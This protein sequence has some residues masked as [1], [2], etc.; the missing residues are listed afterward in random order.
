MSSPSPLRTALLALPMLGLTAF[1]LF[2]GKPPSSWQAGLAL[3]ATY[4]FLNALFILMLHTGKTDRWRSILFVTYGLLFIV[5]FISHLIEVRGTMVLTHDTYLKGETPFCHIVIPM[6]LIPAALTKTIIFPG[7]IVGSFASI[8]SMFVIWIG[9]SLALGRGWCSWGCF[10]GGLDDGFSRVLGRP[11][12]KNLSRHWADLPFAVLLV[13]VIWSAASL[14]PVY[15]DWLCPFKAVTEFSEVLTALDVVKTGIFLT[16]FLAFVVVL[17]VL[18]KKRMQCAGL[19]PFGAFQSG[20]NWV[21]PFEVRID[22]ALCSKCGLC[23]QRCPTFSI[24]E[25]SLA[26]GRTQSTCLKCGQC[27][28]VC[29]KK[30][31]RFHVRGTAAG[32]ELARLLFLYPAFLFFATFAGGNLQDGLTRILRLVSTGRMLG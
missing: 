15:C 23:L 4:V 14:S 18:T 30:A 28:D 9:A 25:E 17:P 20:A 27:V 26:Q 8:A 11:V 1:M 13:I 32:P 16:L 2:G 24:S 5:S 19:C 12:L 22:A 3:A 29:P 31:A 21:N 6:T 7:T 10:F